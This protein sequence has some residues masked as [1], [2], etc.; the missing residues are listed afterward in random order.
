MTV[1]DLNKAQHPDCICDAQ[2]TVIV[3]QSHH[4]LP[5]VSNAETFQPLVIILIPFLSAQSRINST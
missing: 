2:S 1:Y 4:F 3:L 5:I